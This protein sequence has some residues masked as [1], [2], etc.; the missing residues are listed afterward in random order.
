VIVPGRIAVHESADHRVII[1]HT[2]EA[3]RWVRTGEIGPG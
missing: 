3:A 2:A 1:A